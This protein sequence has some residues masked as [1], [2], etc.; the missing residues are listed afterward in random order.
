M[1]VVAGAPSGDGS[2]ARPFG[3]IAAALPLAR[4]GRPHVH[5][6][7]GRYEEALVIDTPPAGL[8]INDL[9]KP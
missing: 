1:F 3:S 9:R 2:Q 4:L 5:V 8:V 7:K 6:A